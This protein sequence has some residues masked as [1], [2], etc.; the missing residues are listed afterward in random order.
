MATGPL[1]L[2]GLSHFSY[3]DRK[4]IPKSLYSDGGNQR[5]NIYELE[6]SLKAKVIELSKSIGCLIEDKFFEKKGPTDYLLKN[7]TLKDRC[8]DYADSVQFI[9]EI[10]AG[11]GTAFVVGKSPEGKYLALTAKHCVCEKN[12]EGQLSVK[13]TVENIRLVFGFQRFTETADYK[14]L[15]K[16]NIFHINVAVLS[17]S[18]E[19]DW[20]LLKLS[21]ASPEA[22]SPE[23]VPLPCDFLNLIPPTLSI[24][25]LG[26]PLGLP[27]KYASG[28]TVLPKNLEEKPAPPAAATPS[29]IAHAKI[30]SFRGNSGSPIFHQ[31]TGKVI[32]ILIAG[33]KDFI[34]NSEGEKIEIV[35]EGE[36]K[37]YERVQVLGAC[38][39]ELID[40]IK[41]GGSQQIE[42]IDDQWNQ[43][44]QAVQKNPQQAIPLL[45][46]LG[47]QGMQLAYL[48]LARLCPEKAQ[49]YLLSAT[50]YVNTDGSEI[51]SDAIYGMVA[52][53]GAFIDSHG[54]QLREYAAKT[55]KAD[56]G[57]VILAPRG[58]LDFG[59]EHHSEAGEGGIV[60]APDMKF[61]EGAVGITSA[62][63]RDFKKIEE[64]LASKEK[65][66]QDALAERRK[67][68][69]GQPS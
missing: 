67:K 59:A 61:G 24:F 39:K 62:N 6:G 34:E 41:P 15:S 64:A 66:R 69:E 3:I 54:D 46:P 29:K 26:Y 31:T 27:I 35:Y 68:R 11:L 49:E 33:N 48:I 9:G 30:A 8:K 25:M 19:E 50:S 45:E 60:V 10:S 65:A 42:K 57:G 7:Q 53:E 20:A 52:K 28:K 21:S 55:G 63:A 32:G 47:K 16:E 40:A 1:S 22:K 2:P 56:A 17:S 18:E 4:T 51:G 23:L 38:S 14:T 37:K 5:K 44:V 58:K 12:I 36:Q 43:A 13:A